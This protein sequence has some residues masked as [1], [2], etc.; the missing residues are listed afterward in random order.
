MRQKLSKGKYLRWIGA[1]NEKT[2]A[3]HSG[4]T[5]LGVETTGLKKTH[6]KDKLT[7]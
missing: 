1:L 4:E 6:D 7:N 5:V 3:L 2:D